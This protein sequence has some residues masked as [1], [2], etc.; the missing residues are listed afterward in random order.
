MC[1]FPTCRCGQGG[2]WGEG[3]GEGRLVAEVARGN[4][5]GAVMSR[6]VAGGHGERGWVLKRRASP[7]HPALPL[8]L[9]SLVN[10]FNLQSL[11]HA[12]CL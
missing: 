3:E 6:G 4:G 11:R 10:L 1:Q 8:A 2:E 9:I 12:C 5:A 7:G